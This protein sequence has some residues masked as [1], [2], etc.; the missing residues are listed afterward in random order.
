VDP[1][2]QQRFYA[3]LQWLTIALCQ[4]I[5]SRL[6]CTKPTPSFMALIKSTGAQNFHPLDD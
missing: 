3:G 2:Q 6:D 4:T 5:E 1:P